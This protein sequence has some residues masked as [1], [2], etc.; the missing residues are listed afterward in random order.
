MNEI[1]KENHDLEYTQRI[2]KKKEN[3]ERNKARTELG[4]PSLKS[5]SY[6]I[7]R[8]M[9]ATE[10]NEYSAVELIYKAYKAK[11]WFD[12]QYIKNGAI[13]AHFSWR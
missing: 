3:T 1:K 8:F 5:G 10:E 9:Q 6:T 4:T 2:N 7:R 13:V 11:S 12:W